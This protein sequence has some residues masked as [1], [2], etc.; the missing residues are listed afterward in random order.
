MGYFFYVANIQASNLRVR[1]EFLKYV[2]FG[3]GYY[4]SRF[5][6]CQQK[7]PLKKIF[8]GDLAVLFGQMRLLPY[9]EDGVA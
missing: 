4:A 9:Q 6:V 2:R 1:I 3:G 7:N 5:G 8:S